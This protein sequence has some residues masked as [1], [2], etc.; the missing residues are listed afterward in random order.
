MRFFMAGMGSA[1]K[2][3]IIRQLQLLSHK[4]SNYKFCNDD[5]TELRTTEIDTEAW[6]ATIRRNILDCFDI[7]VKQIKQRDE[8]FDN[9]DN[10][11]FAQ[12]IEDICDHDN[13]FE[14]IIFDET[15]KENI[16]KIFD[17]E[18]IKKMLTLR[19]KIDLPHKKLFD[20]AHYFLTLEK[21]LEVFDEGYN[22]TDE[23]KVHSR[24]PT[25]NMHN[26][27][28]MLNDTKIEIHDVGG[29]KSELV[30]ML[31]QKF[32]EQLMFNSAKNHRL[33]TQMECR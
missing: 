22:P 23:D 27:K 7:F 21:I 18:A 30:R 31:K 15:F 26:Y 10:K 24:K 13:A 20:G 9:E 14:E 29:Q 8:K 3:T 11:N 33:F 32:M 5:W 28:F 25:V 2:S 6:Q 16:V 12:I 19:N 1:G 4:N 17:D